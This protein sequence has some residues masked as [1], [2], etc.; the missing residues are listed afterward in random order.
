MSEKK[1]EF[2]AYNELGY[3]V[4]PESETKVVFIPSPP[5]QMVT[6]INP[7]PVVIYVTGGKVTEDYEKLEELKTY[8]EDNKV[9]FVCPEATDEEE[10]G[11]TYTYVIENAKKLNVKPG[12]ISVKADKEN[13]EAAQAAA[14]YFMDEL[15]ADDID[16]AEVFEVA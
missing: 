14:D 5:T 4:D 9:V 11:A 2:Y 8:C 1:V 12:E 16:D 13:L 7:R 6:K 10:L 15:D 3:I